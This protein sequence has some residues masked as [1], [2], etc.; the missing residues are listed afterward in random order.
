MPTPLWCDNASV[1][2]KHRQSWPRLDGCQV[3]HESGYWAAIVRLDGARAFGVVVTVLDWLTLT[4]SGGLRPYRV[5]VGRVGSED[6]VGVRE[7]R[8]RR[9]ARKELLAVEAILAS[10]SEAEVRETLGLNF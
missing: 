6:V 10:S 4:A 3:A 7:A 1:R 5:L 8:T 2:A 9:R